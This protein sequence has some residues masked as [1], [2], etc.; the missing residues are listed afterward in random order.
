MLDDLCLCF[1]IIF[2]V[3][4]VPKTLKAFFVEKL[5]NPA[6]GVVSCTHFVRLGRDQTLI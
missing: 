6:A 2:Y 1:A 5:V 3:F 4:A